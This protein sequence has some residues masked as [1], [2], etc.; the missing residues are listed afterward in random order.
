M[1]SNENESY[2]KLLEESFNNTT[3]PKMGNVVEGEIIN[4]TDSNIFINMSGKYDA[5]AEVMDYKGKDGKLTLAVGDVLKGF[6]VELSDDGIKI[7]KSLRKQFA[8]KSQ[9]KKAFTDK[10][11]VEGKVF[12]TVNGGYSV[13]VL[14]VR[15]F[16]PKSQIDI[17][18]NDDSNYLNKTFTFMVTEYE[19]NGR[20]II[21]SRK[22]LIRQE[23]A[24]QREEALANLEPETVVKGIV[25]RL[26]D[27]GG[28]IDLGGIEG[29]LHVSEISWSHI[30]K[31][32]DALKVGEEIDVLIL[33]INGEKISLSMKALIENP[34][35][36]ALHELQEGTNVECKVLRL[37]NF[38]AFVEITPGVEGLIPISEMAWGKSIR[39]PKEVL[40]EGDII[41][42]QIS[43]VD[44]DSR[45][46]NLSLR[47]LKDNPW[48]NIEEKIE[49]GK[50][51]FGTVENNTNFGIFV[52]IQDGITGL[53]PRSK[54]P[55]DMNVNPGDEIELRISSLDVQGQRISLELKDAPPADQMQQQRQNNRGGDDRRPHN[56]GGRRRGKP[57]EWKKWATNDHDVP[58]DNP[59]N[60]L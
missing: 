60:Q 19:E 49:V 26:T 25:R 31:P 16:C 56:G 22:N 24:A 15:A 1:V 40:T 45:K 12:K 44:P 43:R 30:A 39:H 21:V 51:I 48:T 47:A 57:S 37:H 33:G 41:E 34:L 35:N 13:D 28:F 18:M 58:E 53:L 3:E 46:I 11:P 38:G 32:S 52:A 10:I 2:A 54:M 9:I 14:G 55:M 7:S 59:F 36:I 5:Y 29:L 8:D 23:V 42:A 6:I 27:F 4:I 20:N 50:V 17:Y